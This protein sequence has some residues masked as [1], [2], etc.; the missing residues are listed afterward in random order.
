MAKPYEKTCRVSAGI[1][2]LVA[3][4]LTGCRGR[5]SEQGFKSD[6]DRTYEYWS[7]L[8]QAQE[9]TIRAYT[10]GDE[11]GLEDIVRLLTAM[12]QSIEGLPARGVDPDAIEAAHGLAESERR[13]AIF[14][15]QN[16]GAAGSW[17]TAAGTALFGDTS[18]SKEQAAA[19]SALREF[20]EEA[21]T[22]ARRT[23]ALLSS[24]YDREFPPLDDPPADQQKQSIG[25][26]LARMF[27]SCRGLTALPPE[28]ERARLQQE[29]AS[30]AESAQKLLA[31]MAEAEVQ[32]VHLTRDVNA[33]RRDAKRQTDQ[34]RKKALVAELDARA[35]DLAAKRDAIVALWGKL[36]TARE[37]RQRINTTLAELEVKLRQVREGA[38]SSLDDSSLEGAKAALKH[39]DG[40][41]EKRQLEDEL[42]KDRPQGPLPERQ[43]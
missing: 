5:T 9:R 18:V 31:E 38:A 4:S 28:L 6:G 15:Q 20:I 43:E 33:L 32:Q 26:I 39:L 34:S 2:L 21:T 14:L 41:L 12:A 30:I 35:K 7:G 40:E 13:L 36:Q 29:S 25:P 42:T 24:R 3:I 19:A 22:K 17:Q 27:R 11:V 8:S 23:R 16:V 1:A 10:Q 37:Q